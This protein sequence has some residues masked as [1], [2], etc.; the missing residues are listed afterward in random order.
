MRFYCEHDKDFFGESASVCKG[1]KQ[2]RSR[3]AF[4]SIR[5]LHFGLFIL[6]E[7]C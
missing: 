1:L 2:F 5:T 7:E 6:G 4:H 3:L